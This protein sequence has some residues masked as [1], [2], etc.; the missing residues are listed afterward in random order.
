[1]ETDYIVTNHR[2]YDDGTS[3]A[4]VKYYTGAVVP[5]EE[6]DLETDSFVTVD[7]YRRTDMY[8]EV[9]YYFDA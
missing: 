5:V 6:Y 1:M 7:R 8:E 9:E 2:T 3:M 4:V